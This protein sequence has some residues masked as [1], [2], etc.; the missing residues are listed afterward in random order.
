MLADCES[1]ATITAAGSTVPIITVYRQAA[2]SWLIGAR[3]G[4]SHGRVGDFGREALSGR[5][6]APHFR[7]QLCERFLYRA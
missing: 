4:S 3:T 7:R 2:R 6:T 1:V 5:S